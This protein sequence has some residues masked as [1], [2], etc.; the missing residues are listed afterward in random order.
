MKQNNI[1]RC[2][3][4]NKKLNI[5]IHLFLIGGVGIGKFYA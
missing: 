3:E 4:K 5:P 2:H 1:L